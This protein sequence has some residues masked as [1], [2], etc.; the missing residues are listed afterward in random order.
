MA[1]N[2]LSVYGSSNV[3]A[4]P[5]FFRGCLSVCNYFMSLAHIPVTLRTRMGERERL[6][7]FFF[8]SGIQT[9]ASLLGTLRGSE[10]IQLSV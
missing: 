10:Q 9:P 1:A 7:F 3:R 6:S 2:Q 4:P 5:K 8:H